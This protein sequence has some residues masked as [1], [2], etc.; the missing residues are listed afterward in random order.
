MLHWHFERK[1]DRLRHLVPGFVVGCFALAL[2]AAE[3]GRADGTLIIDTTRF[4]LG[5]VYALGHQHNDVS[6][7]KD[8]VKVVLT[9]KPLA[10]SVKLDEIDFN[11]PENVYGVVVQIASN[12]KVTH[13]LVH[14][15]KG[16][17]D[18]GFLEDFPDYHFRPANGSRGTIAGK[19]TSARITT[20]TMTF[21]FDVEF[22]TL[23]Q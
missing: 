23:V 22:N 18:S 20:N 21:S 4:N 9:D 3:L 10:A 2:L 6:K 17:Y 7:R 11:F 19:V 1:G 12:K 5:Y 13:V 16:T 14:Y 15:P 8:D